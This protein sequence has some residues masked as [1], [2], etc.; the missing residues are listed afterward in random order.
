MK[1]A[2]FINSKT[3]KIIE[4][5]DKEKKYLSKEEISKCK[6]F[7]SVE[8]IFDE[9]TEEVDSYF[10]ESE[11]KISVEYKVYKSKNKIK[12]TIETLKNELSSSDYIIIKSYEAKISMS[13]VP[14]TQDYLDAVI[15]ERQSLR[16]K[17]NSLEE[18]ING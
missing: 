13:D 1:K 17:I 12:S 14:Y 16:D 7:I 2:I 9:E 8:P 11:N 4:D 15:Q 18:L 5:F 3:V 6:D 10:V